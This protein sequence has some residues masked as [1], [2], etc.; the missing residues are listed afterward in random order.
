MGTLALAR[1]PTGWAA[2]ISL[3]LKFGVNNC[4]PPQPQLQLQ[5]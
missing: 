5:R 1:L 4:L 3:E 2:L